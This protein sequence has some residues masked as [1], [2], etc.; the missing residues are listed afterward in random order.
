MHVYHLYG[1]GHFTIEARTFKEKLTSTIEAL[2]KVLSA[3]ETI[4]SRNIEYFKKDKERKKLLD[5]SLKI[6]M[7]SKNKEALT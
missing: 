4:I 6:V 1:G 7:V 5:E 2:G 3:S